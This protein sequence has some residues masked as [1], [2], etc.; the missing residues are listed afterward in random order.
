MGSRIGKPPTSRS[1]A[2]PARPPSIRQT[3]VDVPPMSNV[4]A[5]STP[6][7]CAIRAA[8]T[9][10]AAGPETS[11][12]AGCLAASA[13]EQTPPEDRMTSGS[14]RPASRQRAASE[15]R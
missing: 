8:P 7:S 13:S 6:A 10:P 9:T 1:A 4:I 3:S 5:F 15:P 11:T 12:S 2:R 14:D